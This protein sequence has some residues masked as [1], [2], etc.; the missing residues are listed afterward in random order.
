MYIFLH[1]KLKETIENPSS[2]TCKD[3]KE[4]IPRQTKQTRKSRLQQNFG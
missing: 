3:V 4:I 1:Y 2:I